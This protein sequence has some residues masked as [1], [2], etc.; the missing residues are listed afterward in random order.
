MLPT[1][2]IVHGRYRI[3]RPLGRGGMGAV[4]EAVD[5]R[6]QN[7]VAVKQ[8]TVGGNPQA[9]HAFQREAMLLAGLRHHALPV[10]IDYFVDT[11]GQF[12][13]MQFIEGEDLARALERLGGACDPAEVV[14][15]AHAVLDALCYL[16]ELH[17]P[18]VHRDIKPA[19]LKR[20]PKGEIVL[21]DFGLAKGRPPMAAGTTDEDS[22]FGYTLRYAPPE[23]IEWRGTDARSDLY[24]LGATLFHLLTGAPPPP[25]PERLA[26]VRS[27]AP[28]PLPDLWLVNPRVSEP[29]SR[30]VVRAMALDPASRYASAAAMRAALPDAEVEA[31]VVSRMPRSQV[32]MPRRV[33]AAMPSEAEVGRQTDLLVQVRFVG[34][35]LLG[36]E[37]WPTRRR[38]PRIE[39]ASEPVQVVHPTDPDTGVLL[40]ARLRVRIVAPDCTVQGQSDLLVEVPPDDYSKRLAFLLTP[41]REG[42]C[43]VNVEVYGP[44]EVFLGAVPVEV[45]AVA[46]AVPEPSLKVATLAL[47]VLARQVADAVRRGEDVGDLAGLASLLDR[48][49]DADPHPDAARVPSRP[50]GG[51][52][53]PTVPMDQSTGTVEATLRADEDTA[54]PPMPSAAAAMPSAAPARPSAAPVVPDAV[55]AMSLGRARFERSVPARS[56]PSPA[57]I[58]PRPAAVPSAPLP[59]LSRDPDITRTAGAGSRRSVLRRLIAVSPAAAAAVIAGVVVWSQYSGMP[60]RPPEPAGQVAANLP[61]PTSPVAASPGPS[62]APGPAGTMGTSPAPPAMISPGAAATAAPAPPA[63]PAA[64]AAP[65]PPAAVAVPTDARAPATGLVVPSV[66]HPSVRI[67]RVRLVPSAAGRVRLEMVLRNQSDVPARIAFDRASTCLASDGKRVRVTADAAGTA[68]DSVFTAVIGAGGE[69]RYWMEF[70]RPPRRAGGLEVVLAAPAG[71]RE[72]IRFPRFSVRLTAR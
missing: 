45:E 11:D 59:E 20:T 4:Y 36:L 50:T 9:D 69:Q 41:V 49:V 6:L 43:R 21:L 53:A 15:W 70:E 44:D 40:P 57:P 67:E 65:A 1:G 31:S 34:S 32:P 33:D 51:G 46:T 63:P 42:Y 18:I 25:A 62:A 54:A 39:Q 23:Q 2:A 12:L 47:G 30:V 24:A 10:V 60:S 48:H 58:P 27:G 8:M 16:H 3:T 37:D 13:V 5:A 17:P 14:A 66:S 29:L 64:V 19:N 22:F 68:P 35:P 38:P 52:E 28:D 72:A 61:P 55:E 26:A 56:L 71:D 7:A